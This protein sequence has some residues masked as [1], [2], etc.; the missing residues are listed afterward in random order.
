MKLNKMKK[1]LSFV[2]AASM[3]A[4]LGT[5]AFAVEGGTTGNGET[6]FVYNENVFQVT[7]PVVPDGDNTFDFIL[8]PMLAIQATQ[9]TN[10]KVL[11]STAE[12]ANNSLLFANYDA[13]TKKTTYSNTSDEYQIINKSTFA[14]TVTVGAEIKEAA[15]AVTGDNSTVAAFVAEDAMKMGED[16]TAAEIYLALVSGS[17]TAAIGAE[18]EYKATMAIDL[19][20]HAN[21]KDYYG[22]IYSTTT[23]LYKY[24]LNAAAAAADWSSVTASIQL[25]G[26]CND[27]LEAWADLGEIHPEVEL[28]WT[29]EADEDIDFEFEDRSVLPSIEDF[30][31]ALNTSSE[32]NKE[33]T[34]NDPAPYASNITSVTYVLSTAPTKTVKL[35][36]G[37]TFY[38]DPAVPETLTLDYSVMNT[39][40]K[41]VKPEGAEENPTATFTV[42]Y[43]DGTVFTFVITIT[44]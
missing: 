41:T 34:I 7:L 5:V 3:V 30:T 10:K 24:D 19:A 22:V 37:K 31:V 18:E 29:V 11:A 28:T 42:T 21:I 27:F 8:D 17:K 15:T 14:V 23:G 43:N 12:D 25:T 9:G 13:A 2:M 1:L 20:A 26:A 4:N 16:A 39:I 6:E 38:Y 35:A 33:L 32:D 36:A 44:Q 40:A